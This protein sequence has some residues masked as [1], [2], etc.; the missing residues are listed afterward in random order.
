M[1][2]PVKMSDNIEAAD[3]RNRLV[4]IALKWEKHFGIAPSITSS[5]SEIDAARIVGMNEDNYCAA[6]IGRTAVSKDVDFV[7]S[8][9]RYQ[10]TANRPSK[11]PGSFVTL[12]SQ[13]T[14]RKRPF[15]W[16]RLIWILYDKLYVIQEAWEF[17][18]DEYRAQ[19]ENEKRLSPEHMRK[20]RCL[21]KRC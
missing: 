16:D 18:A 5:V 7:C 13:K 1:A 6:G 12:V 2:Y 20:G 14:E 10:V 4:E 11:K 21:V 8:G 19:F 9:I 15:G 17:T 3:L